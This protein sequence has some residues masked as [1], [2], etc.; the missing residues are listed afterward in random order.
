MRIE[1]DREAKAVYLYV[2]EGEHARTVEVEPLRIYVDVDAEGRT[3]GIE[4][5]SLHAFEQ[6]ITEHGGL[7]LPERFAGPQSLVPG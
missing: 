1:Y 4:F 7:N 6:Y 2:A 5:L 3:L